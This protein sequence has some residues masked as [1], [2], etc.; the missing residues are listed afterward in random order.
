MPHCHCQK[1][2]HITA[3]PLKL[4]LRQLSSKPTAENTAPSSIMLFTSPCSTP[5]ST[6]PTNVPL[7]QHQSANLPAFS[8]IRLPISPSFENVDISS[9]RPFRKS[10]NNGG[11]ACKNV[12]S[13]GGLGGGFFG[14]CNASPLVILDAAAK[15]RACGAVIVVY[16]VSQLKR[17]RHLLR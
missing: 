16:G 3:I 11:G 4:A 14:L 8:P 2:P 17:M 15:G 10:S 6:S 7:N 1:T 12:W 13:S 5:T 9:A